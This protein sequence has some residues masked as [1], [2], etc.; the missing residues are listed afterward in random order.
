MILFF[1]FIFFIIRGD[2]EHI[3]VSLLMPCYNRGI[4]CLKMR[5]KDKIILSL[6]FTY[7]NATYQL[8]FSLVVLKL[9]APPKKRTMRTKWLHG[10]KQYFKKRKMYEQGHTYRDFTLQLTICVFFRALQD[11]DCVNQA[12]LWTTQSTYIA[13]KKQIMFP[14]HLYF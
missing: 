9:E 14:V 13:H 5:E 7:L 1:R 8:S 12:A 10:S 3:M 2:N 4:I 6:L 11:W